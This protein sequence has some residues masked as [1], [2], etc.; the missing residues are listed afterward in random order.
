[1]TMELLIYAIVFGGLFVGILKLLKYDPMTIECGGCR[2]GNCK[3]HWTKTSLD[4]HPT[5]RMMGYKEGD[6]IVKE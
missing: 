3:E 5:F 2:E 6:K 4:L 1:M